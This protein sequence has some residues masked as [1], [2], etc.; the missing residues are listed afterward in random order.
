MAGWINEKTNEWMELMNERM[1]GTNE[2]KEW[3][4][5]MNKTSNI[6]G[7]RFST[8]KLPITAFS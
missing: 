8:P 4:T 3:T 6:G 2:C 5:G 1:N 7:F